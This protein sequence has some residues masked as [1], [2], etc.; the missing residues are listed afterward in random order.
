MLRSIYLSL[1]R[2][3]L[4]TATGRTI[5]TTSPGSPL[6]LCA[7]TSISTSALALLGITTMSVFGFSSDTGMVGTG[8]LSGSL[9]SSGAGVPS[10]A[11]V[12]SAP[13]AGVSLPF[14]ANAGS[15]NANASAATSINAVIFFKIAL[16]CF[17]PPLLYCLSFRR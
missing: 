3:S 13:G 12:L 9:V 17:I 2:Y 8:V 6:G 4:F 7:P 1:G 5:V 14:S 10:G 16:T 15:A 11:G